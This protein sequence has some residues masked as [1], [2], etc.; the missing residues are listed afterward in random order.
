MSKQNFSGLINSSHGE[1]MGANLTSHVDPFCVVIGHNH[2]LKLLAIRSQPISD[3][4]CFRALRLQSGEYSSAMIPI[5][6]CFYRNHYALDSLII[7][8]YV[9]ERFQSLLNQFLIL[10]RMRWYLFLTFSISRYGCSRPRNS[11]MG[12]THNKPRNL[13]QLGI[14]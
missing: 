2:C 4:K 13:M 10:L 6:R 14:V 5:F 1:L 11:N 8:S 3:R 12:V 9:P 7:M